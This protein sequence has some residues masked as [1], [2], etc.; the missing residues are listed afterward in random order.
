[1]AS[2]QDINKCWLY[3]DLHGKRRQIIRSVAPVS[4]GAHA[5]N[6]QDMKDCLAPGTATLHKAAP[7]TLCYAP[8]LELFNQQPAVSASHDS[9]LTHCEQLG[10]LLQTTNSA[11][12]YSVTQ[13]GA[14]EKRKVDKN[15][16]SLH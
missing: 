16:R 6:L 2:S 15:W 1:M 10:P 8:K 14:D 9:N 7:E 13:A 5:L 4:V 3:P 11:A 12:F